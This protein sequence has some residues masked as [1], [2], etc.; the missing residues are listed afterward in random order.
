[1]K[2]GKPFYEL[3]NHFSIQGGGM[4]DVIL[5]NPLTNIDIPGNELL[6]S[7]K[8]KTQPANSAADEVLMVVAVSVH[9]HHTHHPLIM[10]INRSSRDN[11]SYYNAC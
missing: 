7:S 10:R 6:F 5:T 8:I 9:K 11:H 3:V 1:M 2:N 4:H